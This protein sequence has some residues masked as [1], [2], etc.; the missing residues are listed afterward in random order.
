MRVNQA[1]LLQDKIEDEAYLKVLRDEL[2]EF[3]L[4]HGPL[5]FVLFQAGVDVLASDRLGR[6][7]LT[8]EGVKQRDKLVYDFVKSQGGRMIS[9]CGG[10]YHEKGNKADLQNVVAA[11]VQQIHEMSKHF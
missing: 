8:L 10:G 9:F 5:D 1:V 6:L 3:G 7:S 11:H 2:E 4:R